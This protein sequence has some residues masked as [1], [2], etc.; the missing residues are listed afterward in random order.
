MRTLRTFSNITAVGTDDLH[1]RA[2]ARLAKHAGDSAV[3]AADRGGAEA[4]LDR[5]RRN[6]DRDRAKP[7]P[8]SRPAAGIRSVSTKALRRS[9]LK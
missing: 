9:R 3:E 4:A 2:D 7:V 8:T 6:V 5:A 1:V